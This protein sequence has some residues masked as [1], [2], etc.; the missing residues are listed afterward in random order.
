MNDPMILMMALVALP[1]G[2]CDDP[3]TSMDEP[4]PAP[5]LRGGWQ[6]EGLTE[7]ET[8]E[9][10][11]VPAEQEG[12]TLVVEGD[13]VEASRFTVAAALLDAQ[14]FGALPRPLPPDFEP[15][16]A[17]HSAH[18]DPVPGATLLD[19]YALFYGVLNAT[20]VSMQSTAEAVVVDQLWRIDNVWQAQDIRDG[21]PSWSDEEVEARVGAPIFEPGY[22]TSVRFTITEREGRSRVT[23]E[24]TG[25]PEFNVPIFT[26][27]WRG[28]YLDPLAES[29]ASP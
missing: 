18:I 12:Q 2:A 13:P 26:A 14:T 16:P 1:L 21:Y 22:Y 23:V 24:Q 6:C 20:T 4:T 8:L 19:H 29:L 7:S 15:P 5:A 25:V 11:C 3:Q 10:A 17:P 9:D 27:H 28:L